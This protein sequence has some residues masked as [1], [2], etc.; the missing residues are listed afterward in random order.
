MA[1]R[2]ELALRQGT[3]LVMTAQLQQSIKLLQMSSTE[4][5]E[6]LEEQLVQNPLLTME[7]TEGGNDSGNDSPT[8]D[9][10]KPLASSQPESAI[11]TDRDGGESLREEAMRELSGEGW[12]S[13]NSDP[14]GQNLRYQSGGGGSASADEDHLLAGERTAEKP[15]L[16]EHLMQQLQVAESD[17]GRRLIGA[18]LVDLVDEAGYI[19]EEISA[20]A[21]TLGTT[22]DEVEDVLQLI[23]NFDPPGIAARS[24]N[25]C[26]ALQLKEQ[27]KYTPPMQKLLENLEL[28]ARGEIRPL[29]RKCGVEQEEFQRM[30]ALLKSL[31]PK[32]GLAF[33]SEQEQ[34][35]V[36][37]VFVY[38]SGDH[39]KVEMNA[40]VLPKLLVNRRYLMTVR[41][42]VKTTEERKY[43]T[44]NLNTANWL[45]KSLD[46]RANTIMRVTAEIVRRQEE[47]FRKGV[48]FLKPLTLKEVAEKLDLHESTISRVTTQK[49]L[50]SPRGVFE[51]KY[52]FTS[53]LSATHGREDVSSEAVKFII[54]E[55]V[56][57][58]TP[59]NV[60]SDE[61]IGFILKTRGIEV[62]RRTVAKYREALDIPPSSTRKRL[63]RAATGLA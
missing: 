9:E 6:Y 56:E 42:Q 28:L 18:Y 14:Y 58:E 52:F 29:M 47:F 50:G 62:A 31:N 36:P 25:E 37:D 53:S 34:V 16:R 1:G 19:R 33:S 59:A 49:Y 23:Q 12:D 20:I 43:L 8:G 39:W 60:Y 4:L 48:R 5:Q 10:V 61:E 45:V 46:Q 3:S 2:P 51:L 63:K 30:V 15:G 7:S 55:I 41:K 44:E 24:L 13:D 26:L 32:P 57:S 17:N 11:A 22:C 54:R 27:G 21:E 40:D 35:V 38:Q